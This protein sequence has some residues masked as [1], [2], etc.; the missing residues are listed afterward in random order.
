MLNRI[1]TLNEAKHDLDLLSLKLTR[2]FAI[3]TTA[4]TALKFQKV[5]DDLQQLRQSINRVCDDDVR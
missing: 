5:V 3:T 1:E 4:M 2:A